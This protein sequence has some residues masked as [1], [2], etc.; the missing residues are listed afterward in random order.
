VEALHV[1]GVPRPRAERP[2][3]RRRNDLGLHHLLL[4]GQRGVLTLGVRALGPQ[5]RGPRGAA[6]THGKGHDLACPGRQG[7][8]RPRRV[9]FLLPTA[10]QFLALHLQPLAQHLVGTGDGLDRQRL[11]HGLEALAEQTPEPL[12]GDT[13]GPTQAS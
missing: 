11:R 10:R 12:A 1:I 8:P 3:L 2:V 4:R 7:D 5:G 6:I 13:Y 9:G